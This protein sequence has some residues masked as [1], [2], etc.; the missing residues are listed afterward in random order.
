MILEE[1]SKKLGIKTEAV[2]HLHP[3]NEKEDIFLRVVASL[4]VHVVLK[5]QEEIGETN[6]SNTDGR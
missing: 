2:C 4:I 1:Q 6:I 5:K 3:K